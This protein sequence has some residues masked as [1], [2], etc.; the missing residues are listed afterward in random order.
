MYI[1]LLTWFWNDSHIVTYYSGEKK[2]TLYIHSNS[3][4]HNIHHPRFYCMSSPYIYCRR[5]YWHIAYLTS[6]TVIIAIPTGIK[7]FSWLTIFHGG[8]IKWSP[9]IQWALGVFFLSTVVGLTGIVLANSS[10]DIVLH[11]T[12]YT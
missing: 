5:G 3:L 10:L 4:S 7:V 1:L 11:D 9:A 2:R 6:A 8:N 12:H